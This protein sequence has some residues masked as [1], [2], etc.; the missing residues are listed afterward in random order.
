MHWIRV[1]AAVC[2]FVL[3]VHVEQVNGK[4]ELSA[5]KNR[6]KTVNEI[7][8]SLQKIS[9]VN[10]RVN[11]LTASIRGKQAHIDALNRRIAKERAKRSCF[12][13]KRRSVEERV[14]RIRR[15]WR[16]RKFVRKVADKTKRVA[17][18][19]VA[20][21][22]CIVDN[23]VSR[24]KKSKEKAEK[25]K[26]SLNWQLTEAHRDML[27]LTKA[28][29]CGRKSSSLPCVNCYKLRLENASDRPFLLFLTQLQ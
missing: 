26:I 19:I 3:F 1:A 9:S 17:K 8:T 23:I 21:P 6:V 12:G 14:P 25:E 7:K 13:R 10:N 18:K 24:L 16:F 22:K 28:M 4:C 11:S 2:L 20:I 29:K 5:Y 15:G 27:F